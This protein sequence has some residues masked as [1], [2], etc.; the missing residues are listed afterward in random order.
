MGQTRSFDFERRLRQVVAGDTTTTYVYDGAGQRV[1]QVVARAAQPA[2]VTVYIGALYEEQVNPTDLPHSAYTSYYFLGSR[3]VGLRRA[4]QSNSGQYRL[5]GDHLG[6]TTLLVDTSGPP[7]VV[8]R[9]YYAPY[10]T[11]AYQYTAHGSLRNRLKTPGKA[12][13]ILVS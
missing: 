8:Q 12:A 1:A 9:Q 7:T 10:G 6:S 3:L 13:R 11:S 2:A 4:N 5:V